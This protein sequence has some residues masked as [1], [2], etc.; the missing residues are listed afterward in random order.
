M[1]PNTQPISKRDQRED[2]LL[3]IH[4]IFY[5]IQGEG[6]FAGDP[7]VFIRLGG[8]NM[9]CPACDTEY[10]HGTKVLSHK[11][12]ANLALNRTPGWPN[13]S[14]RPLV[15]ITGGEPFR[16]NIGPLAR[17][18]LEM[19]YRVQVETNGSLYLED[20]PYGHP[21]ETIVCSPKAGKV[22]PN[23]VGHI[24]AYKYV[25][26]SDQID[27]EDGLPT[28]ALGLPNR[29][30]RPH[31]G[32]RALIYVNPLDAKDVVLNEKNTRQTALICQRFGYRMGIQL[33]K[34]IGWE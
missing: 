19:G 13:A 1:I 8:C 24:D 3:L 18:L 17:I 21:R 5:T 32:S 10:T 20:Y 28:S 2:G 14:Q 16:Q 25:L 9:Q 33:H 34:Y 27:P 22:H 29:P 12:I 31:P 26:S 23:L 11:D 6:P 15:V 4:S 30:A 7:A